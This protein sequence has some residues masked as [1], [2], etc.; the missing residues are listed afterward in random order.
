VRDERRPPP[1]IRG[2]RV[3]HDS[4]GHRSSGARVAGATH[5]AESALAD[6]LED[7]ELPKVL[8]HADATIIL[9]SSTSLSFDR[10][11]TSGC[12]TSGKPFR[13]SGTGS[14]R[15]RCTRCFSI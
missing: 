15:S 13:S 10:I 5:L 1:G 9:T 7:L 14:T 2:D 4:D 6:P 12:S 8:H 3:G 11:E